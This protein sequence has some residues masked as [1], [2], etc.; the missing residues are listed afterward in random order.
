MLQHRLLEAEQVSEIG[1][2]EDFPDKPKG[3]HW[4]GL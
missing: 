2:L 1:C 4:R 3:M